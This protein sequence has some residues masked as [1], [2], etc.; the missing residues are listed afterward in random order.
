MAS[1]RK[2]GGNWFYRYSD[3]NGIKRERRGCA[4]KRAT[5]ELAREAEADAARRR[6]GLIDPKAERIAGCERRP[7]LAH[8]DDFAEALRAKGGDPRHVVQ[9]RNYA[10]RVIEA[11][12]AGRIS[13]LKPS[14]VASAVAGLRADGR[15]ARTINAHVTAIKSFSR[16]L[17]RDGRC[18][19]HPLAT[20]AKANE[21]ADRR[22]V[23]RPLT[24]AELRTLIEATRKAPAWRRMSGPDRAMLYV[25]AAS[26]GLRRSEL[27][28]LRP[29]SFQ[30]DA[31]P[32][33]VACE[34]AY[35]KNGRMAEQPITD[36]VAAVLRP[37]VASRPTDRPVFDALPEK[38]GA[39]LKADLARTGIAADDGTGRVVDMH[40]LRHGYI[41][42]L[43]RSGV[44]IKTLQTLARHSDPKLTLNVYSHLSVSDAAAALDA[45]PDLTG[46]G[47]ESEPRAMTGT[48]GRVTPISE[49]FAHY[50]PTGGRGSVRSGADGSD[51]GHISGETAI[52]RNPLSAN[53]KDAPGLPPEASDGNAPRRTRTYNPLIKSRAARHRSGDCNLLRKNVLG[54]FWS[55]R[56]ATLLATFYGD[57]GWFSSLSLTDL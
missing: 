42:A 24:D 2:R 55:Q 1:F 27:A 6:A 41:T 37:W 57:F 19:D 53:E 33:V 50:L 52:V 48:D 21:S 47:P 51:A 45:L 5:E 10:A 36:A 12:G 39:M 18:V 25:V 32:P 49:P 15:S 8:L 22:V 30:L 44:S 26:T 35:T 43:A 14:S 9:T 38:T 13:E 23:R 7:I 46:D 3:E 16:W 20:L 40:S 34:A 31:R 28:S 56:W 29:E 11:V 54:R 17:W 4:D